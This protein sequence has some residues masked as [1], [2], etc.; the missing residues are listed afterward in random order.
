MS[1]K[2]SNRK[3]IRPKR[4]PAIAHERGREPIKERI[5]TLASERFLQ[6]GFSKVSVN[7][8]T[9]E[10][11]I[12]KKTFYKFFGSKED[13]LVQVMDRFLAG[14][15][16]RFT[17]ILDSER[18]FVEKLGDVMTFLG[19]EIGRLGKPLQADLQRHAPEVWRRIENF[20]R[21]RITQNF[22]LLLEQ[23]MDEGFVRKD[24]NKTIALLSFLG[25]VENIVRPSVLV[26]ESF[27][28]REA[29]QGITAI[30]FHG[31]LTE[32]A[33]RKLHDVQDNR[34]SHSL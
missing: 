8:L 26:N 16:T 20:R 6:E 30:V 9:S 7:D 21:E 14:V 17:K 5:L 23:G 1:K 18:N 12:S 29:L 27:S 2:H 4:F 11:V 19:Q 31:I 28:A 22:S 15:R 25:A 34:F 32:E 33:E 13:L 10:L 3:P 24:L